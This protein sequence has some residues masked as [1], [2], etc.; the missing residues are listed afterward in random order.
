M[1][2]TTHNEDGDLVQGTRGWPQQ[3][4]INVSFDRLISIFGDC[5]EDDDYDPVWFVRVSGRSCLIAPNEDYREDDQEWHEINQW[6]IYSFNTIEA[7]ELKAHIQ[8]RLRGI[9]RPVLIGKSTKLPL[10]DARRAA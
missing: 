1:N 10:P 3:Y 5:W 4:N 2:I 9:K 6:T 7:A 8:R